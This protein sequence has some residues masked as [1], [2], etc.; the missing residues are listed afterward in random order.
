MHNIKKLLALLLAV[1]MV[2]GLFVGCQGE[3]TTTTK[4]P[5][6]NAPTTKA[7]DVETTAPVTPETDEPA[8]ETTEPAQPKNDTMVVVWCTLCQGQFNS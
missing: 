3:T 4:A 5:E 6:T 8:P 7:P 2:A 1:V